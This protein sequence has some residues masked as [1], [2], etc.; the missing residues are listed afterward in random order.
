MCDLIEYAANVRRQESALGGLGAGSPPLPASDEAGE[1]QTFRNPVARD[2]AIG[3]FVMSRLCG[4]PLL[5][6]FSASRRYPPV[7]SNKER[8]ESWRRKY[9]AVPEERKV[10][11]L[12]LIAAHNTMRSAQ[13]GIA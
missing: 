11:R 5:F 4:L 7:E 8:A 1:L 9:E 10:A 2:A 12:P 6:R 3:R 13:Q